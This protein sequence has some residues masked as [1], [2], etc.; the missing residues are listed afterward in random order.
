MD[1]FDIIGPVMIGPSSSHTAGA[2][3]IGRVTRSLLGEPLSRAAIALHGSF[4][5]TWQGH[6]TDRAVIGGL[7]DMDVDDTRLRD[8]LAIAKME[9]FSYTFST[10]VLRDA[11]PNSMLIHAT[12]QNGGQLRVQGASVGGGRIRIERLD[13][14]EVNFSGEDDTLIIRHQDM[15]GVIAQ[16]T[17]LIARADVNIAAMRVFREEAGGNAVMVLELDALPPGNTVAALRALSGVDSVT[18]LERRR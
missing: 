14:L 6:G 18:L 15:P 17:G 12:G 1:L 2:A 4:A 10:A 16:S 7:L 9:G 5:K 8:S 11:H 13:G 3:R